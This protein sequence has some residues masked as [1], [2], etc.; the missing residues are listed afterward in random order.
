MRNTTPLTH[1]HTHATMHARNSKRALQ[2]F[3]GRLKI[4]PSATHRRNLLT[5]HRTQVQG[6]GATAPPPT[7]LSPELAMFATDPT[8]PPSP[9]PPDRDAGNS[10]QELGSAR[11]SAGPPPFSHAHMRCGFYIRGAS[12]LI[13]E[14]VLSRIGDRSHPS[15]HIQRVASARMYKTCTRTTQ[16][17]AL[18]WTPTSHR[19]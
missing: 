10:W 11:R 2:S 15:L 8:P 19:C 16:C 6:I 5:T 1:T 4:E 12:G 14:K 3:D 9:Q 17:N 7:A 18:T 13:D